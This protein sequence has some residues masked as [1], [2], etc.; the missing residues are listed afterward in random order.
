MA[1]I[2]AQ[3]D[4]PWRA[5]ELPDFEYRTLKL[6]DGDD[7]ELAATLVRRLRSSWSE[8]PRGVAL[9]LHGYVDYFFHPHLADAY[10]AAG[11]D[12]WALDL[13]R[14]GRSRRPG[15]VPHQFE[16]VDDYFTEIDWALSQIGA[17]GLPLSGLVGHSTGGLVASHYAGRGAQRASLKCLIL[18]SPFFAFR[19]E[20]L[21]RLALPVLGWLGRV[22]P[23]AP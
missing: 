3:P 12:L 22:A 8:P 13:R 20:P 17:A 18:N 5:D 9:Y 10:R 15:N 19:A 14:S 23:R 1:P 11:F 21:E 6:P 7:G 4:E 2:D 16:V